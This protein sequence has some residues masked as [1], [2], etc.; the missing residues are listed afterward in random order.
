MGHTDV[1]CTWK[2]SCC[3]ESCYAS[4]TCLGNV[5]AN[6]RFENVLCISHNIVALWLFLGRAAKWLLSSHFLDGVSSAC[7][8]TRTVSSHERPVCTTTSGNVLCE[9]VLSTV[10]RGRH[11]PGDNIS[12]WG[13]S[14]T[15]RLR[16]RL[17]RAH[18]GT[19]GTVTVSI[20]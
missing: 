4:K 13:F 10:Q 20:V 14:L 2:L 3:E 12:L 17:W 8:C 15:L 7:S 9:K 1:L 18:Q 5:L 6:R 11:I 19:P 16:M